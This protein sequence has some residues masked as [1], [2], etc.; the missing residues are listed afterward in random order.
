MEREPGVVLG[1]PRSANAE[2]NAWANL[3]GC[4]SAAE[5]LFWEDAPLAAQIHC[6]L[7]PSALS[8]VE[9]VSW[10]PLQRLNVKHQISLIHIKTSDLSESDL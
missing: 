3:A 2:R 7:G 1:V 9:G 10:E 4:S 5:P 8:P 6:L